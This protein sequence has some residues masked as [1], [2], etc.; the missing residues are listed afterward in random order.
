M[1][2]S[3]EILEWAQRAS[4]NNRRMMEDP[5][6]CKKI[7]QELYHTIDSDVLVQARE[8]ISAALTK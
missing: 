4:E 3:S 2:I 8:R 6:Y 7:E 5:E 1:A